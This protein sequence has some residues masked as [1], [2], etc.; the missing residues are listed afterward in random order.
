MSMPRQL[1]AGD[2]DLDAFV[3]KLGRPS[4]ATLDR[5]LVYA[6]RRRARTNL[7]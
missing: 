3:A 7:I 4:R 1:I 2:D 6:W 5:R